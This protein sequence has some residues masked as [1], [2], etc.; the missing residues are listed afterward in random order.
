MK[1]RAKEITVNII[2][3]EERKREQELQWI[4]WEQM[5]V[6]RQVLLVFIFIYF[7]SKGK[8]GKGKRGGGRLVLGV[9][10]GFS[11]VALVECFAQV[12]QVGQ[13]TS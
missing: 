6:V 10:T 2:G 9:W 3:N 4:Y 12:Q 5:A 13:V 1:E 7:L 11:R 8:G